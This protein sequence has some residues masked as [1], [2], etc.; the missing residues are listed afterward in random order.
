MTGS[1]LGIFA[2]A[3]AV[4]IGAAFNAPAYAA[5]KKTIGLALTRWEIAMPGAEKDECPNGFSASS[6]DNFEAQYPDEKVR[7]QFGK[8]DKQVYG[9]PEHRGPNGQSTTFRPWVVEDPIPFPVS[10]SKVAFG[11]NLDGTADGHATEGTCKHQKFSSIDGSA[12]DIDNELYRV[13]ACW[14]GMRKGGHPSEMWNDG[15]IANPKNRFLIEISD[16]D[17]EMNDDHVEVTFYKGMDK[18]TRDAS[19][20]PYAW[21]SQRVD[22]RDPDYTQHTTG[23]IVNGE[24]ITDRMPKLVRP[25]IHSDHGLGEYETLDMRMRLK[26]G[27]TH[28]E[29]LMM[30]YYDISKWYFLTAKNTRVGVGNWSPSSFWKSLAA[31]ADGYKDPKTGQC[32]AISGTYALQAVRAYIVKD[33]KQKTVAENQSGEIQS[34]SNSR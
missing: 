16:V 33:E 25:F 34:A 28:A 9:A 31:H 2:F 30:G 12:S 29:G 18:I 26:L 10:Q 7:E 21:L 20:V 13:N 17:D 3:S 4:S 1:R 8:S 15:L 19:G 23:K 22:R 6:L 14:K 11:Q 32:T 24:L 27:T 5:E